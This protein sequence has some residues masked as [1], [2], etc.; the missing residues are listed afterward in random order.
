MADERLWQWLRAGYLGKRT[1][2]YV[3]AAQEQA[4][5]TIENEDVDA[6]CRVCGKEVESVGHVASGCTDMTQRE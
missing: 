6:N 2:G 4:L 1:E 5:R 3:F